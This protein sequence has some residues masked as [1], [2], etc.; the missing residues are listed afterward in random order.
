MSTSSAPSIDISRLDE[1][2]DEGVDYTNGDAVIDTLLTLITCLIQQETTKRM[3]IFN[4][5]YYDLKDFETH[6]KEEHRNSRR[7]K[8]SNYATRLL[9][10]RTGEVHQNAFVVHSLFHYTIFIS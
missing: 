8:A 4:D 1:Q 9:D 2:I 10:P 6:R 5:Q 7:L 3:A